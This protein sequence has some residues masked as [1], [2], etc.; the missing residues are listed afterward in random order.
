MLKE[1]EFID[2]RTDFMIDFIKEQGLIIKEI[3]TKRTKMY[4]SINILVDCLKK[5]KNNQIKIYDLESEYTDCHFPDIITENIIDPLFIV[6]DQYKD[7]SYIKEHL[8]TAWERTKHPFIFIYD[9]IEIME[10]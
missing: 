5:V 6:L 4:E 7:K 10:C 2:I 9:I 3:D 8:K 1:I